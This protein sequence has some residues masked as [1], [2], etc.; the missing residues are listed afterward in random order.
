M[1]IRFYNLND[2]DLICKLGKN[3][4]KN[5]SFNLD[6][7]SY[8][9]VIEKDNYIIGFVTYSIIY[10]IAEIIDII[11]EE[12]ERKKG[13]GKKLIKKV[14]YIAKDNN[15]N[16]ITLEVNENNFFAI[17]FYKSLDFKIVAKRK[18]YYNNENGYLM[19]KDLR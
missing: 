9:L 13:Y 12:K 3:L 2:L 6:Q 14:I 17:D 16:N 11:V 15:C 10:E 7:F 18:S 8:C 1:N 4:H 19:K 5:Y